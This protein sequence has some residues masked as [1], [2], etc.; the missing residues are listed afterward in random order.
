MRNPRVFPLCFHLWVWEMI[1]ACDLQVSALCLYLTGLPVCDP[2][3]YASCKGRQHNYCDASL[4]PQGQPGGTQTGMEFVWMNWDALLTK[5]EECLSSY[6]FVGSLIRSLPACEWR[7]GRAFAICSYVISDLQRVSLFFLPAIKR[8][9][10]VEKQNTQNMFVSENTTRQFHQWVCKRPLLS[11]WIRAA[12]QVPS[13]LCVLPRPRGCSTQHVLRELRPVT[14]V[15]ASANARTSSSTL[16]LRAG[17]VFFVVFVF[18]FF[19]RAEWTIKSPTREWVWTWK[20]PLHRRSSTL[21][22]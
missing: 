15:H 10:D 20:N 3:F 21:A 18:V 4:P 8:K 13:S 19:E 17:T 16:Y 12:F 2:D 7:K 22:G 9:N 6:L 14:H 1:A 5:S 11:L